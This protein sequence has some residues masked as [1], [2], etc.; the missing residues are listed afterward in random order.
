MR[1]NGENGQRPK[2]KIIKLERIRREKK[3]VKNPVYINLTRSFISSYQKDEILHIGIKVEVTETKGKKRY[4]T[5]YE[6]LRSLILYVQTS[7]NEYSDEVIN[8][9]S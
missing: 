5:L 6:C 4:I 7:S 3:K 1:N 9:L 8:C 2:E